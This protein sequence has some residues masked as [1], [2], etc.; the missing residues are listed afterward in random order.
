MYLNT[1]ILNSKLLFF[2]L[3]SY[4]NT[5]LC[6]IRENNNTYEYQAQSEKEDLVSYNNN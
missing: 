4:N 6:S 5:H 2:L 1:K 3:F